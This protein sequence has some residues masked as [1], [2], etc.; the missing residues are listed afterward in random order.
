MAILPIYKLV[1]KLIKANRR[2]KK[3]A[4]KKGSKIGRKCDKIIA[5][6]EKKLVKRKYTHSAEWLA[7]HTIPTPVK[8]GPGRPRK[9]VVE[10]MPVKEQI[11]LCAKSDEL[12]ARE[13]TALADAYSILATIKKN[14]EVLKGSMDAG[15]I[16]EIIDLNKKITQVEMIIKAMGG[17]L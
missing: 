1:S 6:A 10:T 15:D 3:K 9:I 13:N 14:K 5:N 4:K 16:R 8:R 7:K 11:A 17:T 12:D 2:L